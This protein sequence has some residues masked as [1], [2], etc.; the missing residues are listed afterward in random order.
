LGKEL[1]GAA[2][3]TKY[4]HLIQPIYGISMVY[5]LG[6]EEEFIITKPQ[7]VEY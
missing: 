3:Q 1:L 5:G 4:R 6:K 2:L 7:N